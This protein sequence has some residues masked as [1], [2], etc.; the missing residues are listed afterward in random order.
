MTTGQYS[1][2]N[3]AIV[4]MT[5]D[6]PIENPWTTHSTKDI[7]DNPWIHVSE[8]NVTNP[9]GG[10]GIYGVVHFKNH[11]VGVI[12]IDEAGNTWLVG[13]YRYTLNRYEWEIPEGGCPIGEEL[14][15]DTAKRELKEETGMIAD[16]VSLLLE[17]DLSNSVSDERAYIYVARS[18][19]MGTAEPEETEELVVKK[20]PLDEAIE[21]VLDGTIRDSMSVAGL[22]RL[23][24]QRLTVTD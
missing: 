23:Q 7:Y 15:I 12:P 18:L 24:V 16:D 14:P 10:A 1:A 9:S 17:M 4:K 22:L 3:F 19:T 13:Q 8:A 5:D 20:L 21:M 11:A 6:D 2:G